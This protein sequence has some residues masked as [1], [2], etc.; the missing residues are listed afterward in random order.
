MCYLYIL[1]SSLKNK[2][3]SIEIQSNS[4]S[5]RNTC[6]E[7]KDPWKEISETNSKTQDNWADF[8]NFK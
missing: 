7:D 8:E 5:D 1:R 4:I 3:N 6:L 2:Q